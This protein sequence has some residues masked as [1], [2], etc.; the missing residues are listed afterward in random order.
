MWRSATSCPK[1]P[2]HIV[3]GALWLRLLLCTQPFLINYSLGFIDTPHSQFIYPCWPNMPQHNFSKYVM[4][5]AQ[6]RSLTHFIAIPLLSP[7]SRPQF[8]NSITRLLDDPSAATVPRHD[9]R[10]LGTLH[11]GLGAMS[12]TTPERFAKSTEILR[13]VNFKSILK[14]AA[15]GSKEG[16]AFDAERISQEGSSPTMTHVGSAPRNG[17]APVSV[18]LRGLHCGRIGAEA[19]ALFL[20]TNVVDL[21]HRLHHL[22]ETIQHAYRDVGLQILTNSSDAETS[23]ARKENQASSVFSMGIL[24]STCQPPRKIPD[25]KHRGKL[26]N[27]PAPRYDFRELVNQ[28]KDR[29][30]SEDIRLDRVSICQMGLTQSIARHGGGIDSDLGLSEVF[31]VPLP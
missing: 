13:N 9:I 29:T 2:L 22:R 11:I 19:D 14:V 30:W 18:S 12:L 24:R 28:Y 1:S 7:V 5:I 15:R 10:P 25:R 27:S 20:G 23:R 16:I 6:L 3:T 17:V 4:D 21:T 31:S 26:R 8:R